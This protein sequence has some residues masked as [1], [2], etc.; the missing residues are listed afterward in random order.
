MLCVGRERGGVYALA[1]VGL[2]LCP[3]LGYRVC[4]GCLS[5]SLQWTGACPHCPAGYYDQDL[6][7]TF[8]GMAPQVCGRSQAQA[9]LSLRCCCCC[10]EPM[11]AQYAHA[12]RAVRTHAAAY[13]F[14]FRAL[15][16]PTWAC[17]TTGA[18]SRRRSVTTNTAVQCMGCLKCRWCGIDHD[19]E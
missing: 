6:Y 17:T 8:G 16:T 10:L 11:G 9:T 4:L 7:P 18:P 2:V 3:P 13:Y 1:Y 19:Q 15:R 12:Q 5:V 14:F